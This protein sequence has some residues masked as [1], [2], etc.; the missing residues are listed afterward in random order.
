MSSD[1]F[2][3]IGLPGEQ[4]SQGRRSP[5]EMAC[6]ILEVLSEGQAKPTHILQKANMSWNV[7]S[8]H[9]EFLYG[10]GLVEKVGQGGKRIEYR[11]TAK[12][13]SI[14]QLYEGLRL[15]LKGA[16]N[17]YPTHDGFPLI[18]RLEVPQ[19]KVSSW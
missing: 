2:G 5:M 9:L 17:V 4:L 12:G 10:H 1:I 13:R 8:S 7:L 19:R 3:N 6:D 18:E 11:L 16:A 14:L 15:S